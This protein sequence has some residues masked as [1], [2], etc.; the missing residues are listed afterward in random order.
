M[1]E[2]ENIFVTGQFSLK[3]GKYHKMDATIITIWLFLRD[4]MAITGMT[5]RLAFHLNFALFPYF[6]SFPKI[7]GNRGKEQY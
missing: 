2:D 4:L 1:F 6:P 3:I 7:L 5:F